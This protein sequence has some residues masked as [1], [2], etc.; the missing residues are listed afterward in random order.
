MSES[1]HIVVTGGAGYIGS[2]LTAQLLQQGYRVTVVDNLLFGGES[3]LTFFSHPNFHFA[4]ADVTE[5]RSLRDS[6]PRTW[7][8]LSGFQPARQSGSRRL[9]GTTSMQRKMSTSRQ[10][11]YR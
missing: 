2:L 5:A 9:G 7:Q 3:L 11:T 1:K 8:G 6:L 4:K 10:K